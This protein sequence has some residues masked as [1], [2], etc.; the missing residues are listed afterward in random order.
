M[1]L[2]ILIG[3]VFVLLGFYSEHEP[4]S[5]R[6]RRFCK[7]HLRPSVRPH[8]QEDQ[9]RH[10]PAGEQQVQLQ[11]GQVRYWST[12]HLRIRKLRCKQF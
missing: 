1:T 8:R 6:S 9:R 4:E 7:G 12:R 2:L 5:R 11:R 10:T 3:F